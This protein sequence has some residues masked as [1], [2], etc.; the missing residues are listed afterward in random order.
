MERPACRYFA[1][2]QKNPELSNQGDGSGFF[3][4]A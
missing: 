3:I 2:K 4:A 1:Q